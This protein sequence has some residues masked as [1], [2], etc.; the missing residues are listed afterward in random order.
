MTTFE[1]P[2]KA[3]IS[4]GSDALS[5]LADTCDLLDA[6]RVLLLTTRSLVDSAVLQGV[7]QSLGDRRV[8]EIAEVS[9][10]VP[11]GSISGLLQ[12]VREVAPDL[13]V[14]LG[15]G[16][17]TDTAKA[18]S[19][20]FAEGYTTAEQI[21]RHRIRFTYPDRIEV[22]P[23]TAPPLPIVT[24]PTTLSAAEYDGIFGMTSAEGV[25]ELYSH[26]AAMPKAVILDP[27]ATVETSARLWLGTGIRTLDH[28]IETYLSRFPTPFTDALALQSIELIAQNL[29]ISRRNPADM[30][31]RLN[32]LVAGWLS[33]FGVANVTLG[34]SHGIGHQIGAYS[35]VPHGETSCV[36]LPV[37]AGRIH[38][39][40]PDRAA[41]VVAALGADV[42][43]K[44]TEEVAASL[45]TVIRDFITDLGLPTRLAD[46]GVQ[47]QDLPVIARAAMADMVV[48]FS[49]VTVTE[50]EVLQLL[51]RAW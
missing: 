45:P 21:Y 27:A 39:K 25:K 7:R 44:T 29:P 1:Y 22:E 49:P 30:D 18:L 16:S 51:R 28:A 23:F 3:R 37:V 11:E 42:S 48:A 34:L 13:I 43:G 14:T 41:R 35:G 19:V 36:M 2:Q 32:C 9:Q 33:M 4:Y 47:E 40:L 31:A 15:G 20:G 46:V 8:A 6:K 50:D 5:T 17:V 12:R 24:I 38:E 10:H 26:E